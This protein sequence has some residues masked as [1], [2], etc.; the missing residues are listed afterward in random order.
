MLQK[1]LK[2]CTCPKQHLYNINCSHFTWNEARHIIKYLELNWGMHPVY[3]TP[4]TND[5]FFLLFYA[6]SFKMRGHTSI[7]LAC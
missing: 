2:S 4:T 3:V 6:L 7:L 5:P 1:M